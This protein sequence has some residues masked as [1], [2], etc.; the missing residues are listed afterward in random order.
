VRSTAGGCDDL[1]TSTRPSV[2]LAENPLFAGLSGAALALLD[3]AATWVRVPGGTALFEQGAEPDALYVLLRGTLHV[4][5]EQPGHE[6]QSVEYLAAGALVGELG[7]L[8]G[9]SR[10]A[11][12]RAV[13]DSELLRVPRDTFMRL[14]ETEAALGAAV[15]RLLGQRLKRT[16]TRPRVRPRVRTVALLPVDGQ[17]V[18]PHFL[19]SLLH[20]LDALGVTRS[21]LSS[22]GLE[23]ALGPDTAAVVRGEAGD[24]RILELCDRLEAEH[25]LV[26]Y[27]ADPVGGAWTDR[28]LRQADL[29]LLLAD[30]RGAAAP[31]GL[32]QRATRGR[33]GGATELVLFH[34]AGARVGGTIEWLRH[35]RVGAH[36][37]V[38]EGSAESHERLARFLTG[39]AGG[40]VLSGGGARG[41]AHI[42]VIKALREAGVAIDVVGGSSMGAIIAAQCAAGLDTAAMVDMNRR[43]FS[44]S[45]LS[46]L[47]VPTVALRRARSTVARLSSMFGDRQIEDLTLRYFCVSS[48]LT[49]AR[50]RVHD[51]GPLW[52]WTRASCAI[53]GLVPP[54]PADGSLLVD[55]GLLN[56]LPADVMRDRCSGAVIAVNVTPTVDLAVDVP[57]VAEMSGWPHLWPMLFGGGDGQ[58]FPNIAEI[59]SRTVF[60]GSV[61]DAQAQARHS[62]LYIEPALGDIG[63]GD[64]AAID[65]IVDAGYRTAVEAFAAVGTIPGF[66]RRSSNKGS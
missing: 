12:V 64:F 6:L 18:P 59:L 22:A 36:H 55:G 8:L 61:R 23:R 33:P 49:H 50:V 51:R 26:V 48:D 56:N 2:H 17:P 37:H 57:L 44:G 24:S 45:D 19:E 3:T 39:S 7:V 15:S 16:T 21:H 66:R 63:M 35:R 34:A 46:D 38:H 42:G 25:S 27:E 5:V 13:R 20:A 53:P 11:T 54:V 41:F 65:R 60:V 47:T 31:G 1:V 32:E 43:N 29:V 14:I 52:L 4:L 9:E 58:P 40:L 62:D 28:C 10:S 30:A